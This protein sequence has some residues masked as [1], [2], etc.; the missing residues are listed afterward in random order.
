MEYSLDIQALEQKYGRR[1][2][3]TGFSIT[4]ED[5]YYDLNDTTESGAYRDHL[6]CDGETVT[7]IDECDGNVT[8]LTEYDEKVVMPKE[9]FKVATNGRYDG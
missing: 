1:I 7:V 2:P 8:F 4:V 9:V 5:D 3:G 6:V